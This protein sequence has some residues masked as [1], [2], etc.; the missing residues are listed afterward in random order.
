[1]AVGEIAE[2]LSLDRSFVRSV[3][4]AYVPPEALVADEKKERGLAGPGRES[5]EEDIGPVY[6]GHDII[7]DDAHK[8]IID[9]ALDI[10]LKC[11]D[12]RTRLQ[13]IKF[14]HEEKTGRRTQEHIAMLRRSSRDANGGKFQQ[15]NVFNLEEKKKKARE[16]FESARDG[17][18]VEPTLEVIEA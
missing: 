7:T 8:D 1:M 13:A 15:I 17:V 2:E 11:D 4:E 6:L 5:V 9:E 10:A 12:S 18:I 14:L 3:L 16:I